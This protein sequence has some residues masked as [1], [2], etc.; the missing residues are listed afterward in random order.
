MLN[1]YFNKKLARNCRAGSPHPADKLAYELRSLYITGLLLV[2]MLTIF[3]SHTDTQAATEADSLKAEITVSASDEVAVIDTRIYG[4]FI[5]FLGKCIEG[6]LWMSEAE[7]KG[8][9]LMLG[10]VRED[11][12]RA[13][14]E[15]A[16][17]LLRWPGG[18]F[19]DVY[20][21]RDGV[22]EPDSRPVRENLHWGGTVKNT[23]GTDEFLRLC[24]TLGIKPLIN[25]NLGTGTAQEAADWV[26]Y[27][28]DPPD[29]EFGKLRAKNGH[30]QPYNVKLWGIGNESFG[31]WE[32]GDLT[33]PEKY[34]AK[35][36]EFYHAMKE[37]DP[38]I[39]FLAVG[40]LGFFHDW[41][42]EVLT[43][44]A[45]YID[46]YSLHIYHPFLEFNG[47]SDKREMYYVIVSASGD[48]ENMLT[49]FE[50]DLL[51]YAGADTKIRIALDEWNL[52][53][54]KTDSISYGD[55]ELSSGLFAAD[56]L[57]RLHRHSP[58]LAFAN[59]AQLFDPIPLIRVNEDTVFLTPSYLAFIM[60]SRYAGDRLL[61]SVVNSPTFSN[62]AYASIMPRKDNPLIE[63]SATTT[64]DRS[65]L[66][67]MV[68]NKHYDSPITT[69][70]K[71]QDFKAGATAMIRELNGDSPHAK[72]TFKMKNE[73]RI[74]ETTFPLTGDQFTYTF[75]PHSVTSIEIPA[76]R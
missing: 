36:L 42:K 19:S 7:A 2:F 13:V 49:Q 38:N 61:K 6:S 60:F 33:A 28:N 68:V 37:A 12:Y 41:N 69:T 40:A 26:R 55:F 20:N 34:A 62:R 14:K 57:M 30:P 32:K 59:F 27:V 15:L 70:I 1:K 4:Q 73:V 18:C 46:Y 39:E 58:R 50:S 8:Q 74:T 9:K 56:L 29:K 76:A 64:A 11:V 25:V 43:R 10:G 51:K 23:F 45:D 72:N 3:S 22:G 53:W 44:L 24:E 16:V 52:I 71:I 35:Y 21:W 66:Y 63:V 47:L 54:Q 67:L 17:P 31:D 75:P 48:F 5:E 65:K